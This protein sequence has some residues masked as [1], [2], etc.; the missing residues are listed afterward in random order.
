MI[1][2]RRPAALVLSVVLAACD[3]HVRTNGAKDLKH[4]WVSGDLGMYPLAILNLVLLGLAVWFI[5]GWL[6]KRRS[7]R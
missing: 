7:G 5:V 3:T 1:R 6:G 2:L 4:L